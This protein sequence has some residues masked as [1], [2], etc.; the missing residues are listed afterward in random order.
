MPSRTFLVLRKKKN[1]TYTKHYLYQQENILFL[2]AQNNFL[3]KLFITPPKNNP[4]F[5]AD[6][7]FLKTGFS[8]E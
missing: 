6:Q 8:L 3:L 1:S 7:N 2:V 4:Y 5:F